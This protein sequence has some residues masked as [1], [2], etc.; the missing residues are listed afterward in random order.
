MK[1][2]L[3]S[4]V[5]LFSFLSSRSSSSCS[6]NT[7]CGHSTVYSTQTRITRSCMDGVRCEE[8]LQK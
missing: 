5:V 3:N 6:S 4:L 8:I 7:G 2:L 1:I